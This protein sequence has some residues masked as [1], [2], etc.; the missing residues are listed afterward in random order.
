MS[1]FYFNL[2]GIETLNLNFCYSFQWKWIVNQNN[3]KSLTHLHLIGIY[4]SF[5][6]IILVTKSNQLK[7]ISFSV[8]LNDKPFIF[9]NNDKL[10]NLPGA[11]YKDLNSFS[12]ISTICIDLISTSSSLT[13]LLNSFNNVSRLEIFSLKP[14]NSS[15]NFSFNGLSNPFTNLSEL[16]ISETS[17]II[18]NLAEIDKIKSKLKKY[19]LPI[20]ASDISMCNNLNLKGIKRLRTRIPSGSMTA[21]SEINN[22]YLDSQFDENLFESFELTKSSKVPVIFKSIPFKLDHAIH[23]KTLDLRNVHFHTS[24][25][26]CKILSKLKFIQHLHIPCCAL[27]CD[28]F[29]SLE[30]AV[31]LKRIFEDDDDNLEKNVKKFKQLEYLIS[32]KIESFG[33]YSPEPEKTKENYQ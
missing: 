1:K 33:I 13:F 28:E 26:I 20:L 3:F 27:N 25:S 22:I 18:F 2:N 29:K 17:N 31:S 16:I 7:E 14:S 15:F 23:L 6:N 24:K 9:Q 21:M 11:I 4:T 19:C 32:S 12:K 30:N 8:D 10:D 5:E